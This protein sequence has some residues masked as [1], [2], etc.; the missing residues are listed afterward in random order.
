[1]TDQSSDSEIFCP[2]DR[3]KELELRTQRRNNFE[4]GLFKDRFPTKEE[5]VYHKE[6]LGEPQPPFSTLKRKIRR[7]S[8]WS[9]KIPC[10]I[11]TVYTGHAYID[12]QSHVNIMSR[13]YY[14]KIR[15]NLFQARRNPYQPY[16]FCNFV[17]RAKNMPIDRCEI[18]NNPRDFAKSVKAIALP[19]DV[20]STSDRH[21]IELENQVQ[22]L[23]EA[24][25]APTQPTQVNKSLP[26]VRSAVVLTTLRNPMTPKSIAAISHYER[27]ELRKKGIQSLSKLVSPK[28]LSPTVIR[29]KTTHRPTH[30]ILTSMVWQKEKKGY[31]ERQGKRNEMES[32]IMEVD[33]E[34]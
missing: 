9:L 5:L 21:L 14:N 19:Q 15:E 32:L 17:G 29:K 25:L 24:H 30:A 12:L 26:H 27:E 28:Y 33:E 11:G 23:M 18:W 22:Y 6:L 4:E 34:I 3:I 1:M 7:G 8:P 2:E 20:P 10:V 13:A 16:K 31:G